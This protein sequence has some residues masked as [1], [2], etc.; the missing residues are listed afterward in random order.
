LGRFPFPTCAS[1][2]VR[3]SPGR[4]PQRP[5][6]LGLTLPEF[7]DP[8][9][10]DRARIRGTRVWACGTTI[11]YRAGRF[12]AR[13]TRGGQVDRPPLVR[14]RCLRPFGVRRPRRSVSEATGLRTI[15]LR[16]W[17]D[18]PRGR[19]PCRPRGVRTR[20]C[21]FWRLASPCDCVGYSWRRRPRG[22][23]VAAFP[24]AHV[25]DSRS[26]CYR[27]L[28][29]F[30]PKLGDA[31]G[32]RCA[33]RSVDPLRGWPASRRRWSDPRAVW[34]PRR[35]RVYSREIRPLRRDR[36]AWR[37]RLLGPSPRIR[38]ATSSAGP[39]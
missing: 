25:P 2:R 4:S 17:F 15:P 5:G 12:A 10:V 28:A 37:V 11:V 33:L 16:R 34:S 30:L 6:P 29:G 14:F 7:P 8:R 35:P 19:R 27:G 39:A 36:R 24:S 9:R 22:S 18:L 20:P 13:R 26:G 3:L 23:F 31:R 38:C 32:V 1:V 21:G